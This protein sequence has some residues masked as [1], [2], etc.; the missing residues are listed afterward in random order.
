MT[1]GFYES[2]IDDALACRRATATKLTIEF[3]KVA[4]FAIVFLC[5]A[6]ATTRPPS[7]VLLATVIDVIVVLVAEVALFTFVRLDFSVAAVGRFE[8]AIGC[9]PRFS[10]CAILA[11]IERVSVRVGAEV[12]G[13]AAIGLDDAIAAF[14]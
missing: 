3:A 5:G 10:V 11:R 12:A 14:G 6:I 9:A 8:G 4:C 1:R 2:L 13:F 7:A